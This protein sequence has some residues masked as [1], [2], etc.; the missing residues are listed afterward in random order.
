MINNEI[1]QNIKFDIPIMT[2]NLEI[3]NNIEGLNILSG[4]I[5]KE[6]YNLFNLSD[7]NVFIMDLVLIEI[8]SNIINYS[9]PSKCES[10]IFIKLYLFN[11]YLKIVIEDYGIPFNPLEVPD[12]VLPTS[13]EEADIGGLGI[14]L[15]KKYINDA[16][17]EFYDNK[18]IF[19]MRI[20]T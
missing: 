18:N 2:S 12:V 15:V 20:N 3:N 8:V 10:K 4:W 9:Y 7:R 5:N 6:I 16:E 1:V 11:N 13:L 14:H 19:T 17:Y